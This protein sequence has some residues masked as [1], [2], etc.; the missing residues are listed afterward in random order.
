MKNTM[1]WALA[2]LAALLLAEAAQA[3]NFGFYGR[4]A[5]PNYGPGFT[6]GLSPYLNIIR[7]R[8]FGVD[9]FLGAR[10]EFARRETATLFRSEIDE[11]RAREAAGGLFETAADRPVESGTPVSFGNTL[12][13]Y[14][15]PVNY[16]MP[17]VNLATGQRARGQAQAFSSRSGRR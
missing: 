3:Q 12:G 10:A 13:F 11:L 8:N 5:P 16:V 2:I 6:P 9:Y 17:P 4:S 15:N 1:L 14:N 7:G